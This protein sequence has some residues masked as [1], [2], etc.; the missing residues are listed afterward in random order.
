MTIKFTT[1]GLK[2]KNQNHKPLAAIPSSS[3]LQYNW[4]T[5]EIDVAMKPNDD[6]LYSFTA[7]VYSR[8]AMAFGAIDYAT[9]A[10]K[11]YNNIAHDAINPEK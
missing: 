1:N 10:Y 11:R 9:F 4:K 2:V 5:G 8:A 6:S 3:E 7:S